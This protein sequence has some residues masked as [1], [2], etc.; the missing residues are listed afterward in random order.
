MLCVEIWCL[1]LALYNVR[2]CSSYGRFILMAETCSTYCCTVFNDTWQEARSKRPLPSL[3]FRADRKTKM[4]ALTSNWLRYFRLLL[5]NHWTEFNETLQEARFQ[6]PLPCLCFSG[7]L[8]NQDRRPGLWLTETILT[9]LKLLNRTQRNLTGSK[10]SMSSTTFVLFGMIETRRLPPWPL[11]GWDIFDFV[12][13]TTERNSTK[14]DSKQDLNVLYQVFFGSIGKRRWPPWPLIGLDIFTSPLK[15]LNGIQRNSTGSRISM[16]CT[17]FVFFGPIGKPRLPPWPLICWAI[18]R[19]IFW[20]LWTDIQRNLTGRKISMASTNF[21]FRADRKTKMV[22]WPLIGFI[23]AIFEWNST[24]LERRQVTGTQH[25]PPSLCVCVVFRQIITS[26][27]SVPKKGVLRCTIVALWA[28]CLL[29]F[30]S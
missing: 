14:H 2:A 22:A 18:F 8:E 4:A 19:F 16:S 12:F 3:C 7:R 9:F 29:K 17:T 28:S 10:I 27:C 23:S 26:M 15:S 25:L 21:M 11:I 6:P 20:N 13:E 5:W 24:K 30:Y 1:Y